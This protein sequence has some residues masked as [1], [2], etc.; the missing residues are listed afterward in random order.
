MVNTTTGEF[1]LGDGTIYY[2]TA[3]AGEAVVLSHAAFIDSRMFDAQWDALAQQYQVIR[4]DMRGFG[5]SSP[6]TGPACRRDDLSRLLD[7]LGIAQAH[8]V[9][10]SNGGQL[11]LDLALEQA[12]RVLSLTIVNSAPSGFEPVGEPPRHMMA[13]FGAM[14]QGDVDTANELSVRIWFDGSS[15]EPDEPDQAQRQK[16]LDMNRIMVE[17]NTFFIAD[18][19]P[20]RPLDPPA[21]TRL[22]DVQCPVLVVVG[23]LDHAEMLC[24]AD[25]M[26]EQIPNAHKVIIE[27]TAHIPSF[28]K[29]EVFNPL[30]VDFLKNPAAF[31][32]S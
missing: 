20:A 15:R 1:D 14:Q 28:E 3:G 11:S 7:H 23:A 29:P 2:E 17:R 4:Y 30:L 22:H 8:F 32:I 19:Q 24:A 12:E 6:V 21:L 26:A 16:V 31:A 27:G 25:I 13:M 18:M 5:Q 10:C 9:G